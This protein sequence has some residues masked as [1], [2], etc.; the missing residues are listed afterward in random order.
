MKHKGQFF[1]SDHIADD[2]IQTDVT[3]CNVDEPGQVYGLG[4][5]GN[6]LLGAEGLKHIFLAPNHSPVFNSHKYV[7]RICLLIMKVFHLSRTACFLILFAYLCID[8]IDLIMCLAL[9]DIRP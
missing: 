2:H 4:T 6:R 9:L 8:F 3:T 7:I 5:F 1:S